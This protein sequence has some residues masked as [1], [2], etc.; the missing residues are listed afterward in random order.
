VADQEQKVYDSVVLAAHQNIF[1]DAKDDTRFKMVVQ[2]LQGAGPEIAQTVGQITGVTL[3]NIQGAA[4]KQQRDVPRD[5]IVQAADEVVDQ[6]LDIAEAGGLI[7]GN[8][9]QVKKQALMEAM[10]VIAG[11]I[12]GSRMKEAA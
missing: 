10:K 2:R 6:V 9:D 1:G 4:A 8:R 11:G 5:V 7:K 3:A 12:I